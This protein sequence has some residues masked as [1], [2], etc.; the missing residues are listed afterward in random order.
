MKLRLLLFQRELVFSFISQVN[1]CDKITEAPLHWAQLLQGMMIWVWWSKGS[2][3][4]SLSGQPAPSFPAYLRLLL[5]SAQLYWSQPLR[6]CWKCSRQVLN[7]S[8]LQ[9]VQIQLYCV[10]FLLQAT[11]PQDDSMWFPISQ[12][13]VTKDHGIQLPIA[14]HI[15]Q[16]H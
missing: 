2:L 13:D 6:Q 10:Q 11:Q 14:L 4:M 7:D 1:T 12:L 16:H 15:A 8:C 3:V 9:A 5:E